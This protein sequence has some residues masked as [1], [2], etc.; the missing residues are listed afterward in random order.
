MLRINPGVR[1]LTLVS[2][3]IGSGNWIPLFDKAS[4]NDSSNI[5]SN[6]GNFVVQGSKGAVVITT[7]SRHVAR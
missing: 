7:R 2:E 3:Y 4:K 1:G 6:T 5:N